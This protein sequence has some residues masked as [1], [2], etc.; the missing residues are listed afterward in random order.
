MKIL[1]ARGLLAALILAGFARGAAPA[2]DLG[3]RREL[4]VDGALVV[5]LGGGAQLRLHSPTPQEVAI[6]HDAPWEGNDSLFHSVFQD[7]PLYRMY[8]RGWQINLLPDRL[9]VSDVPRLCYAESDD[10]IHWRKPALGLCEFRGSKANN[11]VLLGGKQMGVNIRVEAS[12]V[13]RDDNPAAAPAARYKTLLN[14]IAPKGLLAFQSPDGLHWSPLSVTPILLG[15]GFDSQNLAFWDAVSGVYRIYW[16][17]VLGEV[18]GTHRGIRTAISHDFLHWQEEADLR[19]VDSPVE[20]LYTNVIK[21]YYRAPQIL[22]GFPTRYVDRGW[23]DS[24]RDLPQLENRQLRARGNQRYGTAVTEVV[25]MAGRDGVTFRRW[26]EAFLRPG[27]ERPGTWMYGQHYMA[28]QMVE[29]KSALEG[30][31]NEISLY[32]SEGTWI[33]HQTT[34]RRYTLRLDGFVSLA[35]PLSGGELV[36]RPVRF[37]GR[38]LALNFSTSAAGSVRVE[39]EDESG[40]PYPGFALAD[41]PLTFGD[42]VDRVLTWKQGADLGALAGRPIRLRFVLQDADVY[43]FW[44][45]E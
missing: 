4:F 45:R 21:P 24:T 9:D 7:G 10:G 8:Y 16:R 20:H 32:S 2:L 42:S 25:M 35:A 13:F 6:V 44:F 31:P 34:M 38:Q 5:H 11:I 36:T 40:Q 33:G 41:A 1:P 29:T 12:A 18:K 37:S 3:T 22:I 39:I 26:N 17:P 19:Y 30:A 28:W 27:I 15:P 14:S 43:S 23:T